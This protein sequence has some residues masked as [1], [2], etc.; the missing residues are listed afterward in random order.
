MLCLG[1]DGRCEI[2]AI[3]V[4][5]YLRLSSDLHAGCCTVA[6]QQK[7]SR[8]MDRAVEVVEVR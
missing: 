8:E 6:D 1:S 3:E 4:K 2:S 7:R 5:D